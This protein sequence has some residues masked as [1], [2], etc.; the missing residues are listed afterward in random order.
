MNYNPYNL[1]KSRSKYSKKYQTNRNHMNPPEEEKG[2]KY[3]H[4]FRITIEEREIEILKIIISNCTTPED[5]E[6][7]T[8]CERIIEAYENHPKDSKK[9]LRLN[10]KISD[11]L[12][13]IFLPS[14]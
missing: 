7:K 2:R 6:V 5:E 13:A 14:W 1:P 11:R 3:D 9:P 4:K 10:Q 8:I 12:H